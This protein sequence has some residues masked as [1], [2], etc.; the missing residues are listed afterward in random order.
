MLSFGFLTTVGFHI[1]SGV[2]HTGCQGAA[3]SSIFHLYSGHL[4]VVFFFFSF[5]RLSSSAISTFSVLELSSLRARYICTFQK[6]AAETY[7]LSHLGVT[8]PFL[9]IESPIFNAVV[10]TYYSG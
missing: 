4:T 8:I 7:F 2:L 1:P 3:A 9:D 10:I 6:G 5:M